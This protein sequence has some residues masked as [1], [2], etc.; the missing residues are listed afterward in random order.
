[1]E[2]EKSIDK[3]GRPTV[4]ELVEALVAIWATVVLT[5][6]AAKVQRLGAGILVKF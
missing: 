3:D 5:E 6:R 1:M 4:P 2:N